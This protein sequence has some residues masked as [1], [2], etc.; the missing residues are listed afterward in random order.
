MH[1]VGPSVL[2]TIKWLKRLTDGTADAL[3]SVWLWRGSAVELS[4][5]DRELVKD[6]GRRKGYLRSA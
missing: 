1:V 3:L 6:F 5:D 4:A 2:G